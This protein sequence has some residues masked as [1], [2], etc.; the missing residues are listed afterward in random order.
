MNPIIQYIRVLLKNKVSPRYYLRASLYLFK[1][2]VFEPLRWIE[3]FIYQD[4]IRSQ[5]VKSPVFILGYYRSGTTHLQ[6]LLMQDKSW[7][8][9][10][11]FQCIFPAAF[12]LTEKAL[13]PVFNFVL[14][15]V[16]F[17]HPAH[18]IPLNLS[19]PAEEDV[20]FVAS[21]YEFASNWGQVFPEKFKA[22]FNQTVFFQEATSYRVSF[23][24]ELQLLLKRLT[25][26]Y[27]GKR[28]LM[29]SPPQTARLSLLKELYPDAKFIFIHRNPYQVFKS[30]QK[31]W[32]SFKD[33][34]LHSQ[35][36]SDV[37]H[38]I[39]WS[40]DKCLECYESSSQDCLP[41]Q[42]IEV[43]FDELLDSPMET[44]EKI[45]HQLELGDFNSLKPSLKNYIDNKHKTNNAL[46]RY[47]IDDCLKVEESC[48]K[49]IDKW[50]YKR[51]STNPTQTI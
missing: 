51:P 45:Y 35:I 50:D 4:R 39:L 33:Q 11:F 15:V 29:K 1:F 30:N 10:N 46:H 5:E 40:M 36:E 38:N 32:K 2:I 19:M 23:K 31:L 49:W 34:Q 44:I 16:N 9:L 42:L 21:G 47:A 17:K 27:S 48:Q 37:D 41:E 7:G 25:Y 14:R 8:Y 28:L 26:S 3:N 24:S 20:S 6:E 18:R 13:M 22:Y 43:S 12:L